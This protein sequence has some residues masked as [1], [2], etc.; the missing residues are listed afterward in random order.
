MSGGKKISKLYRRI[1]QAADLEEA[2][3]S[4]GDKELR[5]FRGL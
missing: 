2:V 1:C 3:R 5:E 4:A